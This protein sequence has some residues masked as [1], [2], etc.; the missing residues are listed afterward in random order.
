MFP[1]CRRSSSRSFSLVRCPGSDT[2]CPSVI[3]Y[4]PGCSVP[5]SDLFNHGSDIF[6]FSYPDVYFCVSLYYVSHL[7]SI[8]LA[9]QKPCSDSFPVTNSFQLYRGS[10]YRKIASVWKLYNSVTYQVRHSDQAFGLLA[11][12]P[13]Y[14]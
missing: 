1:S 2:R 8:I 14:M 5:S 10:R 12:R 6:L 7:Q 4:S 13:I 3:L 9:V 11:R